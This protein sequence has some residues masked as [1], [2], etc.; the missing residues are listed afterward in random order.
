MRKSREQAAE[1]RKRIVRA[2]ACA[3]REK[4]IVATGLLMAWPGHA[5]L[6]GAVLIYQASYVLDCADGMLARL[7]GVASPAG[8][9]LDFLMDEL[10]AFAILAGAA[11]RLQL[12][13]PAG[14]FLLLGLFVLVCLAFGSVLLHERSS[15]AAQR[16]DDAGSFGAARAMEAVEATK[17]L[18]D[19]NVNPQLLTASLLQQIAPFVR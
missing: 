14:P 19:G 16:G 13:H 10:K 2:A 18:A 8:H 5:G 17:E 4:G 9:L 12:E 11:V 6:I 7:R 3:F 15:T 1:T